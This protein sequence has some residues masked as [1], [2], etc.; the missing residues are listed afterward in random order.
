MLSL[1]VSCLVAVE[2]PASQWGT[3]QYIEYV[4]GSLPLLICAGHG[5]RLEPETIA[6]RVNGIITS[7]FNTDL[8]AV[9][10]AEAL[11]ER[12]GAWPHLV[13][14]HLHR[15]KVDPNRSLDEA[16]DGDEGAILAWNE[17]HAFIGTARTAM[18]AQTGLGLLLDVHGH[19]QEPARLILGY[20]LNP[21]DLDL[22]GAD[23]E[24]E[25]ETSSLRDLNQRSP[26]TFAEL[27]CG[28]TSFGGRYQAAGFPAVPS[29]AVPAPGNDPFLPGGI[30]PGRT[31]AAPV[32]AVM[33][34]R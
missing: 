27:V 17:Y 4:P 6:D 11:A 25:A 19:G 2:R 22:A 10:I 13:M 7:D 24:A 3:N 23:F 30:R 28:Q 26:A 20:A 14:C 9:A 8:L 32:A 29:P 31:A 18:V 34:E 12:T 21:E 5:G 33:A 15:R 1:C 16:T